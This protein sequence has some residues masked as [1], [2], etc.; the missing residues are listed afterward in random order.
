MQKKFV[1]VKITPSK[2]V[3]LKNPQR[4]YE[5]HYLFQNYI[6]NSTLKMKRLPK[7]NSGIAQSTL[8]PAK[9]VVFKVEIKISDIVPNP[10]PHT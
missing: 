10:L 4:G 7:Q 6:H 5:E 8:P 9:Q 3:A 1:L 2:K